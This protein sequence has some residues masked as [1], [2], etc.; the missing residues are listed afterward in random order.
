MPIEILKVEHIDSEVEDN[1]EPNKDV[2][3]SPKG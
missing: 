1:Q 2:Q 3:E